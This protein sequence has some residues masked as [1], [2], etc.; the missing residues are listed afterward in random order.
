MSREDGRQPNRVRSPDR[1]AV[2][3]GHRANLPDLA[4]VPDC[5]Q[6]THLVRLYRL[7][8][9]AEPNR[10]CLVLAQLDELINPSWH[11]ATAAERRLFDSSLAQSTLTCFAA[12]CGLGNDA[13][14]LCSPP[15]GDSRDRALDGA[16]V[17]RSAFVDGR[18]PSQRMFFRCVPSLEPGPCCGRPR[19]FFDE[20]TDASGA[21]DEALL[22]ETLPGMQ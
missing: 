9:V 6:A 2:R 13:L 7:I 15:P 5:S 11:D 17:D 8:D 22:E 21:K 3:C 14:F 10:E 18:L 20:D 19:A 1:P 4:A 12:G 16:A